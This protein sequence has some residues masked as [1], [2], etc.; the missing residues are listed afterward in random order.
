MTQ[1]TQSKMLNGVNVDGLFQ[2]IDVIKENS[3]IAKFNFKMN[4]SV[5]Q[6]VEQQLMISMVQERFM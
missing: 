1:Q 2:T 6:R 5:V 3:S 4:G